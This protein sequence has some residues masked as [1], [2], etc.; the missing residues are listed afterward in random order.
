[1]TIMEIR[2]NP[3]R[4]NRSLVGNALTLPRAPV[5]RSS[6]SVAR[7]PRPEAGAAP[8]F[9]ASRASLQPKSLDVA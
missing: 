6:P 3:S 5:A 2:R 4:M 9:D 7:E 1:M 8:R